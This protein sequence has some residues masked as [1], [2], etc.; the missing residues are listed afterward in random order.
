MAE[1]KF[2]NLFKNLYFFISFTHKFNTREKTKLY[3]K[4]EISLQF[5]EKKKLKFG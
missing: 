5:L 2:K 1:N 4:T 3:R